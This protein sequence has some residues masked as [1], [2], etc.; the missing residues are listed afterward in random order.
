MRVCVFVSSPFCLSPR[1]SA[2]LAREMLFPPPEH[3]AYIDDDDDDDDETPRYTTKALHSHVQ[4]SF[5]IHE[6]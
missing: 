4:T 6:Y 1:V 2:A 3:C 5:F